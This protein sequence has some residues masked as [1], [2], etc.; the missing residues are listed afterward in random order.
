MTTK[1]T[2]EKGGFWVGL[3]AAVFYPA[4]RLFSRSEFRGGDR[5][6]REGGALVVFNHISEI[7][8]VYDAVAVHSAGRVP[9]FMAKHSLWKVPVVGSLLRGAGQIP[10]YRGSGDA[11]RSLR[12]AVEGLA[13][14]KVV[15]IYPEGTVGRDPDRWPMYAK[16]GVARLALD[17]DVPVIPAV[18]WGTH[19]VHDYQTKKFRPS[20]RRRRVVVEFGEP[21]DL[22]AYRGRPR[23]AALLREVT[24]AVM[25]G[26]RD[27]LGSVRDETPPVAFHRPGG[28]RDT[29]SATVAGGG[30]EGATGPGGDAGAAPGTERGTGR[31]GDSP[32]EQA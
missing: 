27:L 17:T 24:D 7:D 3:A 21:V 6:P 28:R 11:Q 5:L 22:G 8:P 30:S 12:A 14:G 9:R 1:V 23:D 32:V 26:V 31:D 10:V 4:T 13:D 18:N 2:R 15:V 25:G 29:G 16:T 20:R 19:E